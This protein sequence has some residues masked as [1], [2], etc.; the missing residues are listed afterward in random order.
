MRGLDT[1]GRATDANV[2]ITRWYQS[3]LPP[4]NSIK[5]AVVFT[6]LNIGRVFFVLKYCY[7]KVKLLFLRKQKSIANNNS[8]S[9]MLL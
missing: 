9:V 7:I 2:L 1:N 6:E 8:S 3:S 5:M 4:K